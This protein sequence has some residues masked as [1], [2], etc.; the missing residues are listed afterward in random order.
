M[1]EAEFL[2]GPDEILHSLIEREGLDW[3]GGSLTIRRVLSATG[4]SRSFLNDEPITLATLSGIGERLVD[5]HSQHQTIILRDSRFQ[6]SLL[7]HFAG[8]DDLLE[9]CGKLFR[10]LS[11]CRSRL[12]EIED[13]LLR[14]EAERDYNQ[15][16]LEQLEKASLR[17]GEIE[18]LEAEHRQLANAEEIKS[19]FYAVSA[20]LSP[21]DGPGVDSLLKE[22]V[23]SLEKTGRWVGE[24][25]LLSERTESVR[26]ELE[27]IISEAER[28]GERVSLSPARLEEV[29]ERLSLL[30]TLMK[31]FGCKDV[32]GLIAQREALSKT[33][34]D[35]SSLEEEKAQTERRIDQLTSRHTALCKSLGA[36]R[37]AAAGDFAAAVEASLHELELER[38]RFLVS[39]TDAVPGPAGADSVHYLFSASGAAPVD[40]AKCASGGEMSRIM[41]CLKAMMAKYSAMPS[42]IF[43]EID[44]GVSG[45]AADRMGSMICRMGEDMQIFAITHLP[46]VAAKG[47]SHFLVS[48]ETGPS[49][50]DVT[51]IAEIS[52]EDRVR[53]IARMLSGSAITPEAV[54]N[55]KSLL[56]A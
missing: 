54:A 41:L 50:L 37:R 40:V 1:V 33:L 7:D 36:S 25:S 46:Q 11:S 43:D 4:R 42:M 15:A 24:A 26:L 29:E 2:C 20:L 16:R 52:G 5:I 51:R 34:T 3:N 6:L 38:A 32:E 22:A 23:K 19:G 12:S 56:S 47:N 28:L 10:E 21:E 14:L 18:E 48:K 49:G 8:N 39:V 9:E 55:A 44:T 13:S 53:E 45:S 30:Y 31:R 27:D 35:S 17:P